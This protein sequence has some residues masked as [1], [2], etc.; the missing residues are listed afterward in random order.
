MRVRTGRHSREQSAFC[1]AEIQGFYRAKRRTNL[2][3]VSTT[4]PRSPRPHH[5]LHNFTVVSRMVAT[6]GITV[7]KLLPFFQEAGSYLLFHKTTSPAAQTADTRHRAE[8]RA[9]RLPPRPH[10]A[11]PQEDNTP[12]IAPGPP[13]DT[14]AN[15]PRCRLPSLASLTCRYLSYTCS[16]CAHMTLPVS[17]VNT[18]TTLYT[19]ARRM[20][21]TA[22]HTGI[23]VCHKYAPF[24]VPGFCFCWES[25]TLH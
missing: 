1:K 8:T 4:S 20:Y 3:M 17:S 7:P 15:M 14:D 11:R 21:A 12:R 25:R 24:S 9:T 6:T 16:W 19:Q 23:S 22:T 13:I 2:T 5:G 10:G 18:P